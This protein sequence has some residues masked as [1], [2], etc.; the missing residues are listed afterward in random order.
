MKIVASR[1]TP[2]ADIPSRR[3]PSLDLTLPHMSV[4]NAITPAPG[5]RGSRLA[6]MKYAANSADKAPRKPTA[7]MAYL[8]IRGLTLDFVLLVLPPPDEVDMFLSF[9]ICASSCRLV[10]AMQGIRRKSSTSCSAWFSF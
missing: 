10:G 8:S 6:G 7:Y 9:E 1:Q 4:R 3:K 5:T 2:A